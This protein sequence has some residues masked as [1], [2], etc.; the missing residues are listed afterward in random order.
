[1][2]FFVHFGPRVSGS[3]ASMRWHVVRLS[4]GELLAGAPSQKAAQHTANIIGGCIVRERGG[5]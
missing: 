4:D 5:R 3:A 1:M 2:S